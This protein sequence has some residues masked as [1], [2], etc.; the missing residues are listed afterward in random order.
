M[1]TLPPFLKGAYPSKWEEDYVYGLDI[2]SATE[3]EAG[4]CLK[5]MAAGMVDI[6]SIIP[7]PPTVDQTWIKMS[8]GKS[9]T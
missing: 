4:L 1:R 9:I 8:L 2:G 3:L 5:A 7:L 6:V